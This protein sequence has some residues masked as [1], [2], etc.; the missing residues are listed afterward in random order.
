MKLIL[1]ALSLLLTTSALGYDNNQDAESDAVKAIVT[2]TYKQTGIEDNVNKYI[3]DHVPKKYKDFTG[4]IV[5]VVK[6]AV[7][8][9]VEYN[10]TF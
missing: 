2:A 4:N 9:K 8:Q 5:V 6:T 10:W 1:F 7:S 3:N